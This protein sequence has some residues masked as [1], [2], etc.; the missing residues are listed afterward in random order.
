MSRTGK[1]LNIPKSRTYHRWGPLIGPGKAFDTSRFFIFCANVMGSPY[2][3]A[4]PLTIDPH[5]GKR[6]GPEFPSVTVRDDV[7][8]HKRILEKLG[9]KQIAIVIG[10]SMGGMQVLEW[11]F[12]GPEFVRSIVPIA[13]SAQHSAWCISW[14]EAQRQAIYSDPNYHDG[15]YADDAAP[16]T[17]LAAARMAAL[18]TYRSSNSF[19]SRFGRKTQGPNG[20]QTSYD[21]PY[22]PTTPAEQALYAHNDGHRNATYH[23][24]AIPG[25]P[26]AANIVAGDS[27]TQTSIPSSPNTSRP[28]SPHQQR[29]VFSA[30][31]YLRYQGDKFVKRFDANCYISITRKMDTHDVFRDR[32][33][34]ALSTL[35]QPALVIGIESDGL[36]PIAEQQY[37]AEQIKDSRLHI[38]SSPDGHDGFLL[39][40]A[41]LN[42]LIKEFINEVLPDIAQTTPTIDES[43]ANPDDLKAKKTST[44]GEVEVE[45]LSRW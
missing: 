37:L 24:A 17:G 35:T 21:K 3:S 25:R 15:Y 5:T 9:V 7:R 8:A 14:G 39:E 11:A 23:A 33:L 34:D 29:P 43:L 38:V 13:T 10:G 4:S 16:L 19:E 42:K 32:T 12:F 36:F 31:S 20:R 6:Y 22:S 27:S 40:F 30:Q 2:G 26:T 1:F 44:F 18:L 41:Q 28:T 45:D